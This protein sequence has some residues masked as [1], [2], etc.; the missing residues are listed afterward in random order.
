[1]HKKLN[2]L[3]QQS[4]SLVSLVGDHEETG[5]AYSVR[6]GNVYRRSVVRIWLEVSARRRHKA[7]RVYHSV[8]RHHPARPPADVSPTAYA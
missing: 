3:K 1:M 7:H 6:S 4:V 5:G 2:E 8:K